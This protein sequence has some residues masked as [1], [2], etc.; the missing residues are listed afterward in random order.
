MTYWER[1]NSGRWH[2]KNGQITED[3][4]SRLAKSQLTTS[5]NWPDP[6]P[7]NINYCDLVSTASQFAKSQ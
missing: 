4:W 3:D 7:R 1:P 5:Q 2:T 6:G